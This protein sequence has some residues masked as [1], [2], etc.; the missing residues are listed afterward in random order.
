MPSVTT[1]GCTAKR[2]ETYPFTAPSSA[3]TTIM[4]TTRGHEAPAVAAGQLRDEDRARRDERGDRE[5][6]SADEHDDRLPRAGQSE[7]RRRDE[8]RPDALPGGEVR[9]R[10]RP[11]LEQG[12]QREDLQQLEAAL[13]RQ[14]T[15]PAR[16]ALEGAWLG[17]DRGRP[18]T[19]AR[20]CCVH[21]TSRPRQRRAEHDRAEQDR[22]V[23]ELQPIRG[24]RQRIEQRLDQE[25]DRRAR[26]RADQT[27]A[28]PQQRG[29]AD[30]DRRDRRQRVLRRLSRIGRLRRSPRARSRPDPANTP[31]S[32]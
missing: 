13:E 3:H 18:V 10:P 22:A 1:S 29:P 5:I 25:H 11:P 31:P 4:S 26:D 32:V 28:P 20:S 15:G 23:D 14:Q 6:D 27:A 17:G 2:C 7:E 19:A 24:H 16:A 12:D 30:G 9:D 8:H 21:L